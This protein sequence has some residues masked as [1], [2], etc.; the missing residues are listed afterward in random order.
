VKATISPSAT[1]MPA[2]RAWLMPGSGARVVAGDGAPVVDEQHL[3]VRV[4]GGLERRQAHVEVVG[5][6]GDRRHDH[7]RGGLPVVVD[8][9][10]GRQGQVGGADPVD[11]RVQPASGLGRVDR[12]Q[13]DHV[14]WLRLASQHHPRP[15]AHGALGPARAVEPGDRRVGV[16][17]VHE[18]DVGRRGGGRGRRP[19]GQGQV[20]GAG[21]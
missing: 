16:L 14:A 13:L 11:R 17:D 4:V 8:A 15:V 1:A 19:V 6:L 3:E 2:R 18:A 21:R 5:A 7:R 12:V 10:R 9:A 20:H